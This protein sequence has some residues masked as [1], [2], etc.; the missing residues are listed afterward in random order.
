MIS[1]QVA[2]VTGGAKRIGAAICHRLASEGFAIMVHCNSSVS[3]AE[4]LIQ[5]LRQSGGSAALVS[6]DLADLAALPALFEAAC[7]PFGPPTLLV[8]N[9]SVFLDDRLESLEPARFAA[10]LAVNLQAPCLLAGAFARALPAAETGA[11][12]NI[13]DQRV[14]RPNPQFFSYT[15]AKS[16][17]LT[18]TKTM[19]QALAPRIRVNGV[20]PG[21]TLPN[22][23]DGTAGFHQ[24][25]A[26]TLLGEAVAP[27]ALA[28]AVLYL[29]RA[30]FVTGQMIAVD[31][32]QHLGWQTPDITGSAPP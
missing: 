31:S 22:I 4:A 3:E 1:R 16:A 15:L 13:I 32:G 17:L 20:G 12:V 23:H 27:E 2:L 6:A 8:N 10:N 5:G 11:I 24:E 25:A 18:A 30:R 26:G 7:Q 14:F 19:A 28:E 9:A 29:A 21:P